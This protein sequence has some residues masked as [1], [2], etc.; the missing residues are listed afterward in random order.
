MSDKTD[1]DTYISDK[2]NPFTLKVKYLELLP[3]TYSYYFSITCYKWYMPL[4]YI[5]LATCLFCV[6]M[7]K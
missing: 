1:V 3:C 2:T 6:I 5:L 7:M 4:A